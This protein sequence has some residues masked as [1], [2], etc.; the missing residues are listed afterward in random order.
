MSLQERTHTRT[1]SN[2]GRRNSALRKRLQPLH[3]MEGEGHLVGSLR[4]VL[5]CWRCVCVCG[6]VC[7]VL[8]WWCVG[9]C[10]YVCVCGCV[11]VCVCLPKRETVSG[12]CLGCLI[13]N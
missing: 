8:S 3:H 4:T 2:K 9:W 11:C 1:L 13:S 6:R 5:Q 7:G 10:W 12:R